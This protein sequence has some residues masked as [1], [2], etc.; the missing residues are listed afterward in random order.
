MLNWA[1]EH[2]IVFDEELNRCPE[3]VYKT[4]FLKNLGRN[5]CYF[6]IY[7]RGALVHRYVMIKL[8]ECLNYDASCKSSGTKNQDLMLAYE[9]V[10]YAQN[11]VWKTVKVVVKRK[12]HS[13][14][15]AILCEYTIQNKA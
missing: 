3:K 15:L 13:F 2:D 12:C 6:Q 11:V 4:R 8:K 9:K 7:T 1:R 14:L 5:L 10:I